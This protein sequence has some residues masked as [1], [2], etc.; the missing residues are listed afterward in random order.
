MCEYFCEYNLQGYCTRSECA[1]KRSDK[2]E[3]CDST[4]SANI[5]KT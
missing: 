5:S 1:N 2:T 3:P 4:E